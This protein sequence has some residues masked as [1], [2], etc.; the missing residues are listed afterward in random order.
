MSCKVNAYN[1]KNVS[2]IDRN[3]KDEVVLTVDGKQIIS[4][5]QNKQIWGK[6]FTWLSNALKRV[7]K[8]NLHIIDES[9]FSRRRS[10]LKMGNALVKI[11]QCWL[12]LEKIMVV[13]KLGVNNVNVLVQDALEA[14]V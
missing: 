4:P 5:T 9:G 10:L 1:L 12:F 11:Y 7:G 6:N 2:G 14:L 3:E 13:V 8:T